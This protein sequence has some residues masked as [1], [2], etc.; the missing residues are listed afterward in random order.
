M[1]NFLQ[2]FVKVP[3]TFSHSVENHVNERV[4]PCATTT[5]ATS[6]TKGIMIAMQVKAV[7]AELTNEMEHNKTN[8]MTCAPSED[9][10]QTGHQPSP[11]SFCCPPEGSLGP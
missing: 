9:S 6:R 4:G 10:D 3:L 5:I 1:P 11:I 2:R 7:C 8:E